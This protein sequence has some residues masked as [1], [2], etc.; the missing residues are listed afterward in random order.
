M[1][2]KLKTLRINR[3]KSTPL[4]RGNLPKVNFEY[5]LIE[6]IISII[7]ILIFTII[8]IGW[9]NTNTPIWLYKLLLIILLGIWCWLI[10]WIAKYPKC[11]TSKITIKPLLIYFLGSVVIIISGKRDL[12]LISTISAILLYFFLPAL[13]NFKNLAALAARLKQQELTQPSSNFGLW[14][15][16][17]YKRQRYTKLIRF[18]N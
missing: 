3:T 9:L 11:L 6:N 15:G 14:L 8:F 18:G 7:L 5:S 1:L 16:D 17:V 2:K 12:A 10:F 13:I 4:S